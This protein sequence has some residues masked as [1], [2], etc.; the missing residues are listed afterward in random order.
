ML[1]V[2]PITETNAAYYVPPYVIGALS[3]E[4]FLEPYNAAE[5]G[6]LGEEDNTSY[7]AAEDLSTVP[8]TGESLDDRFDVTSKLPGAVMTGK[9]STNPQSAMTEQYLQQSPETREN[10][11]TSAFTAVM[12]QPTP[13]DSSNIAEP[14]AV[15]PLVRGPAPANRLVSP[16][17]TIDGEVRYLRPFEGYESFPIAPDL[18]L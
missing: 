1:M 13:P 7:Q 18:L 3:Y 17:P 9:V 2:R 16:H 5:D 14:A 15:A 11:A 10:E 8:M 4:G 12:T 6:G